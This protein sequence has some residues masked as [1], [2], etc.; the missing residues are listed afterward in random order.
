MLEIGRVKK[1]IEYY[2]QALKIFQEDPK[3]CKYEIVRCQQLRGEA[4]KQ[5]KLAQEID[6]SRTV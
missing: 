5:L 6:L 4:K 3:D 1:A 2:D